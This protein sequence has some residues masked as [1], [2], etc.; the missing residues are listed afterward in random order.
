MVE[1]L[2]PE[3][4]RF[5]APQTRERGG[6]IRWAVGSLDGLRSQSWNVV[7][8]AAY[9]DVY[10]GLR[11]QMGVIKLSLHQSGQWRMAWTED[12]A[13]GIGLPEGQD[14]VITR[15]SPPQEL[16][17]GWRHAVTVLVTPDSLALPRPEKRLG[18]VPFYPPP[19]PDGELRFDVM[20]GAPGAE[21]TITGA[22]EV[23]TLQLPS[24]GMIGVCLH[25]ESTT[26]GSAAK[27]V[28]A[29]M[30]SATQYGARRTRALAWGSLADGAVLLLDPGAVE[31]EDP[32]AR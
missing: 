14:R 15:W 30:L 4:D 22:I 9:D 5:P 10:I 2:S 31:P 6:T 3:T 25:H 12:G 8:S 21:L 11:T 17:P 23:G 26:L 24:G 7:G 18:R 1:R 19:N 28:R 13:Q 27:D 32:A 20:L 16:K 29:K